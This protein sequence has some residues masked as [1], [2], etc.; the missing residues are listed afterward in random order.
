MAEANTPEAKARERIDE[1]LS[2]AG[3]VIQNRDAINLA[4]AR[5]VVVREAPL[6]SGFG[7]ADYLLYVD[8]RAIG[9]V[10]AKKE[11]DTLAGVEVQAEKY[12]NGLPPS[13]A[14]WHRP[15]PFLYQ[16]TGG[17]TFFTNALDPDP[18]ARLLFSFHRPETLFEWA[19][20]KYG[21]VT[22][23]PRANGWGNRTDQR[24]VPHRS[25]NAAFPLAPNAEPANGGNARRANQGDYQLRKVACPKP[26]ACPHPNDDGVGQVVY[27][28]RRN[29][30]LSPSRPS[31]A[32]FVP[33]GQGQFGAAGFGRI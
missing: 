33:R 9:V 25:T 26:P 17:E 18:R 7:F 24:L 30:P 23:P 5:G 28:R 19:K 32:R 2:K 12:A 20:G 29:V 22:M 4:A 1:Q 6:A 27:C 21:T 11:G 31:E 13:L 8:R 10:E 14:A 16:S 15:L 3:W